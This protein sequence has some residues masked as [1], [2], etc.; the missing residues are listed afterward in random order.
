LWQEFLTDVNYLVEHPFAVSRAATPITRK[1]DF[2][3]FIF[4]Q[5]RHFRK[6]PSPRWSK[7]KGEFAPTLAW[8]Q[9][10]HMRHFLWII[11]IFCLAGCR[12]PPPPAP[13][14]GV[15]IDVPFVKIRVADS[16]PP[17]VVDET[18]KKPRL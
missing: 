9:D 1:T 16:P 15:N 4:A 18:P 10:S 2:F 17:I 3:A 7:P 14:G 6:S 11:A 8:H 12:T 5:S 13:P